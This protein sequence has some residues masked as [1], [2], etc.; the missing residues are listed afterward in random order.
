MTMKT[1]TR[2]AKLLAR[3]LCEARNCRNTKRAAREA[4]IAKRAAR[5]AARAAAKVEAMR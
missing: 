4:R 1:R 5:K 3:D 2:K